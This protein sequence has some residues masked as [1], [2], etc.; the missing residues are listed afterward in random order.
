[1]ASHVH[2]TVHVLVSIRAVVVT[3]LVQKSDLT[4]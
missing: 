1:M 4:P 2:H 3:A